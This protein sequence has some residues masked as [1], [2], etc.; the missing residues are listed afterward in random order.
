MQ[1]ANLAG[2]LLAVP[3]LLAAFGADGDASDDVDHVEAGLGPVRFGFTMD[4]VEN[5]PRVM[6]SGW[7]DARLGK[8]PAAGL[9]VEVAAPHELRSH[10]DLATAEVVLARGLRDALE[11]RGCRVGQDAPVAGTVR[12]ETDGASLPTPSGHDCIDTAVQSLSLPAAAHKHPFSFR[13]VLSSAPPPRRDDARGLPNGHIHQRVWDLGPDVRRCYEA[14]DVFRRLP[15]GRIV[16]NFTIQ[17]DGS[18][19]DVALKR[20]S[21]DRAGLE[22]CI[23]AKFRTLKFWRPKTGEPVVVSF[24]LRF[25]AFER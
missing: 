22:R 18:T 9:Q 23:L 15:L 3:L 5:Q 21:L 24:P 1:R 7:V 12:Y 11:R 6:P 10:Q 17:P 4:L 16:V 8:E 13:V 25:S 20:S 14:S 19:T 2:V